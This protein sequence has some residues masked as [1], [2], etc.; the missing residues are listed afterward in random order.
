MHFSTVLN[1]TRKKLQFE[2]I[3]KG[4]NGKGRGTRDPPDLLKSYH[5]GDTNSEC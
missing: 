2:A 3:S 5:M 4:G 1:Y